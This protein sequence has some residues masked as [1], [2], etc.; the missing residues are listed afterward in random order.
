M[1]I[2]NKL[3]TD[4]CVGIRK[5]LTVTLTNGKIKKFPENSRIVL[6]ATTI[7]QSA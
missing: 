6:N 1:T 2:T 3:F 4:P 5:E 7:V